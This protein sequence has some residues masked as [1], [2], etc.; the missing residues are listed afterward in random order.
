VLIVG[1]G[2]ATHWAWRYSYYGDL[3]PNTVHV[4]GSLSTWTLLRG[5][6]YVVVLFLSFLP[7][8]V[9]FPASMHLLRREHRELGAPLVL[10]WWAMV[11]YAI[12]VGGDFMAMGRLLVPGFPILALMIGLLLMEI[13]QRMPARRHFV[14]F[15]LSCTLIV[16]GLLP[17]WNLHLIPESV[18]SA[19]HFRHN[20]EEF[21]SEFEQWKAMT[22][23][24]RRWRILGMTLAEYAQSGDSLANIPLGNVG[25]YSNLYVY[26]LCGLVNREVAA[27]SSLDV[28]ALY[29]P[30]DV[31][32]TLG[33]RK[34]SPGHDKCVPPSFFLDKQPAYIAAAAFEGRNLKER[35]GRYLETWRE[36]PLWTE[37]VPE[38]V[39]H[40]LGGPSAM[41]QVLVLR[42][43]RAG[44]DAE[45]VWGTF[46]ESLD[47]VLEQPSAPG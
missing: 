30:G 11:G 28:A 38:I 13:R 44:E 45:E 24:S 25:Y 22:S 33:L 2:V 16:V 27:M 5:T 29:P 46:F 41:P 9:S 15:A 6:D 43:L 39:P 10:T 36:L 21:F 20:D 35:I 19:F 34:R 47:T 26:D 37:Y 14:L 3:I 18:R 23:R 32:Q 31:D 1:I 12:L 40:N 8:F 4:K 17:T 42:R 7:L